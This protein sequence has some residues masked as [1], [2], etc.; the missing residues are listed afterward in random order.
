[1]A[2]ALTQIV[3]VPT[4]VPERDWDFASLL[5]LFLTS[6]PDK[7]VHSVTAPLGTSD[8]CVVSVKV[9]TKY[10]KSSD[11]PFHRKVY[12]FAKADWDG[13]RSFMSDMPQS[14]IFSKDDVSENVKDIS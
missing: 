2:F 5:D 11:A 9:E 8:H 7:C 10:K 4:H 1:M 6:V 13:F 12:R 14:S 3:D